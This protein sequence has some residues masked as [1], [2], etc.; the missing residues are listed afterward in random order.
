[1]LYQEG[2]RGYDHRLMARDFELIHSLCAESTKPVF[3]GVLLFHRDEKL[4][5]AKMVEIAQKYLQEMG[6]GH[7][8]YAIVKHFDT[9]HIHLHLIVNRIDYDGNRFN[10]YLEYCISNDAARKLVREYDLVPVGKKDLRQTNFDALNASETRKYAIYRCVQECLP[11]CRD[12]DELERRLLRHDIDVRYRLDKETG[13]RIGISF[14]YGNEAFRGGDVDK[15]LTLPML[16][17]R[18]LQQQTL[19]QWESGKLAMRARQEQE[20]RQALTE[21]EALASREQ[22]EKQRLEKVREKEALEL[23][24][25]TERQRLERVQERNGT[26]TQAHEEERSQTQEREEREQVQ[27]HVPRLRMH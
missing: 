17:K 2:V 24:Q 26:L 11:G 20:Q 7:H 1:V 21:K 15:D 16:Q 3:H 10:P 25:Q 9:S 27:R 12:L 19:G 8:Q 18:L 14:K 4:D 6:L 23:T 13:Q 5:D 22:A